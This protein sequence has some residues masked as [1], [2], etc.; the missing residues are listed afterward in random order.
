MVRSEK[1]EFEMPCQQQTSC[2]QRQPNI[3]EKEKKQATPRDQ[4]NHITCSNKYDDKS[5]NREHS[6]TL[7]ASVFTVEG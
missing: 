5:A 7:Y 6:A 1:K 4:N 3:E 2:K